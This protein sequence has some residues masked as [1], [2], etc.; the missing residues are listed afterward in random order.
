MRAIRL[1]RLA[2]FVLVLALASP[3]AAP[4]EPPAPA[5]FADREQ[6]A[7]EEALHAI[8]LRPSDL[9]YHKG[10]IDD[11]YRLSIVKKTLHDPLSVPAVADALL[12]PARSGARPS[13]ILKHLMAEL[14]GGDALA[15]EELKPLDF[16]LTA[17]QEK[18]LPD[19]FAPVVARLSGA[20]LASRAERD[21][22]LVAL[23]AEQ[24]TLLADHLAALVLEEDEVGATLPE[25]LQKDPAP[26]WQA[27]GAVQWRRLWRSGAF[28]MGEIEHAVAEFQRIKSDWRGV[29]RV[30]T[31][32]GVIEIGGV[33]P[34]RHESGAGVI[35]DLGGDDSYVG[36]AGEAWIVDLGG[37]DRYRGG[38]ISLGAGVLDVRVLWDVEGDDF[39]QGDAMTQGFGAF[40]VGVLIDEKGSDTYRL[41]L[42]GQG[43][44]R[45]WG[46]GFLADRAGDDI[47]QAGGRV[48]HKPLLEK[49]RATF[50]FAQGFSIGY[51][52]G[53]SGGLA[54]L[55]DGAGDDVYIGGTYTQGASYWFSFSVLADDAGNDRYTAFYYSQAS[56]MHLTVAAMIDGGGHDIYAAHMGAIH[57]IGHDWGVALLWDKGGND[58]YAGDSAPGVGVANGVGIFVDSGGDDR[59]TGPPA[60][61]NPARDSGSVALFVDLGGKDKY[62][63]GLWNGGLALRNP[64]GVARDVEDPPPPPATDDTASGTVPQKDPQ[65][66]HDAVGSRPLPSEEEIAKVYEEASLWAVG[67]TRDRAWIGRRALVEMGLPAAKWMVKERLASAQSLEIE[68]FDSVLREI[69][70]ETGA[71]LV[72]PLRST[73]QS[74]V[75]NALRLVTQLKAM[76]AQQEI[77]RLLKEAPK[78]RRPTIAA[79][80]ALKLKEAVPVMIETAKEANGFAQMVIAKALGEIA[81]SSA[82]PWLTQNFDGV[83]LP[84]REACADAMVKIG[85]AGMESLTGLARSE[86]MVPARLALRAIGQLNGADGVAVLKERAADADWGVRLTA[87]RALK[88]M[89]VEGAA[90]AYK[91]ALALEKDPRVTG[92]MESLEPGRDDWERR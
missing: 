29:V 35:V 17:D 15:V 40:G 8:N 6:K 66:W 52:P 38:N 48:I 80:G 7:I 4:Q 16:T 3:T 23:S 56:A 20:W 50:G 64:W 30:D 49:E 90:E 46:V 87:L 25:A 79:A 61:A 53:Q 76:D 59:Y 69:G 2:S 73:N 33:G 77:L 11:A 14:P 62:G 34:D 9:N 43:A 70:P 18:G 83:E 54:A 39:Y 81:D 84:V 28:M 41:Q 22:A 10:P 36:P 82:I 42:Y 74:E 63:R 5:G 68:A 12:T 24:K 19:G 78:V 13:E 27:L 44:S 75:E 57:A 45:T 47:Y 85:P 88:G 67:S 21:A 32:R 58:V 37:N 71:L 92:A 72:E 1:V 91:A 51:R 31:P 86:S 89:T 26:L 65:K 55:W 60:S